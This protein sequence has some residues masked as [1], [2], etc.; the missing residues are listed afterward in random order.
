MGDLYFEVFMVG[1]LFLEREVYFIFIFVIVFIGKWKYKVKRLE[2][3]F[4]RS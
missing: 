1:C 4:L 3:F 2:I